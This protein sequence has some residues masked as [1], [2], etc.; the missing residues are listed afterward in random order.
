[1]RNHT[2]AVAA[3]VALLACLSRAAPGLAADAWT[4]RAPMPEARYGTM[5]VAVE[6]QL[7]VFGGYVSTG[8][9]A[10]TSVFVYNPASNT[11]S[12]RAPMPVGRAAAAIASIAGK[13]YLVG[14]G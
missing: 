10:S 11:W 2:H 13:V 7:F 3:S 9:D 5:G 14:G 6:G 4:T 1:M 12:E 8:N